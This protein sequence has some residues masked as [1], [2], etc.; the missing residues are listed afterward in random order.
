MPQ[1]TGTYHLSVFLDDFKVWCQNI[2]LN[3][4]VD[5]HMLWFNTI[6][7]LNEYREE[8]VTEGW[9]FEHARSL[10]LSGLQVTRKGLNEDNEVN[11]NVKA[12]TFVHNPL[13]LD[14]YER[15][16]QDMIDHGIDPCEK[17][18]YH[19]T[20]RINYQNIFKKGLLIGGKVVQIA[21]GCMNGY[22]VY[23]TS[24]PAWSMAHSSPDK[25]LL[26][27][28]FL[29]GL[30]SPKQIRSVEELDTTKYHSFF[31][32]R[33]GANENL[34]LSLKTDYVLPSHFIEYE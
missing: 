8:R 1:F 12:V 14:R 30:I 6:N 3:R 13:L 9:H 5:A 24:G 23:I 10:I 33:K 25:T 4:F 19:G 32:D 28:K 34:Y 22:G 16:K 11:L 27:L 20:R 21:K 18:G 2:C 17:F 15:A 31:V 7:N 26:C 29:T